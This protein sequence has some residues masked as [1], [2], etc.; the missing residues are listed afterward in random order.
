MIL[1]CS[2]IIILHNNENNIHYL[3]DSLKAIHGDFKKEYIII[4]DGSKDDTLKKLQSLARDLPRT[5]IITHETQGAAM[6]VNKALS[7][8]SGDYIHFVEGHEILHPYSTLAMI[9]ACVKFGTEVACGKVKTIK[10]GV[11]IIDGG[12]ISSLQQRLIDLPIAEILWGNCPEIR[13]IGG[14]VSLIHRNLIEKTGKADD[15]IY[16]QTMSMSLRCAKY[17]KFVLIDNVLSFTIEN[18]VEPKDEKF[19]AY[20][21]LLAIYNFALD[22][23]DICKSLVPELIHNLRIQVPLSPNKLKYYLHFL[24]AKYLKSANLEKILQFY[25]LEYEK[26]F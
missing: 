13:H 22:N 11:H 7:L 21:N 5:T 6:S 20:N 26:L 8:A 23:A 15:S 18:N 25:K 4:D 1:K 14:Q 19:E 10:K 3:I 24:K 16:S 2:Y 12:E 17:S 9:D